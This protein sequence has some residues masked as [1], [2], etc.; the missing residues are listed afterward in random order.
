[1]FF[2]V[3]RLFS[4]NSAGETALHLAARRSLVTIVQR[5]VKMGASLLVHDKSGNHFLSAHL[6]GGTLQ[7]YILCHVY[8]C[9]ITLFTIEDY[10]LRSPGL[11]PVL[12]VDLSIFGYFFFHFFCVCL[13]Q[14]ATPSSLQPSIGIFCLKTNKR[15]Y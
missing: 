10:G 9:K 7:H 6:F 12:S 13:L 14:S 4:Q 15:K 1:M 8:F 3:A 5:L 11:I 2:Q